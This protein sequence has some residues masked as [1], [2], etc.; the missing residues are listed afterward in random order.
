LIVVLTLAVGAVAFGV[1]LV[2]HR[3]YE[4]HADVLLEPS[5]TDSLFSPGATTGTDPVRA[6]QTETEL[7]Q[8]ESVKD[9]VRR[10]LDVGEAPSVTAEPVGQSNVL[11]ISARDRNASR[12]A[13]IANSYANA[14]IDFRKSTEADARNAA[15]QQLQ[16]QITQ[17]A[18]EIAAVDAEIDNAPAD[19][20]ASVAA[21]LGSQRDALV[22]QQSDLATRQREMR[23][24]S[25]LATGGAQ[26]VV[27]ATPPG[28]AVAPKPVLNLAIGLALGALL[29]IGLAFAFDS[30]DRRSR[31]TGGG[32]AVHATTRGRA[33]DTQGR[34]TPVSTVK[35]RR[36]PEMR[37]PDANGSSAVPAPNRA[38]DPR[39][40]APVDDARVDDGHGPDAGDEAMDAP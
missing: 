8:S 11:R 30:F 16:T 14:Y 9:A 18:G 40:D 17:I 38:K 3:Q 7:V 32:S 26:L 5:V 1:S 34:E 23:V 20:Q 21:R 22:N 10:D 29:G 4:A 37:R 19:Q 27:T 15:D 6:M 25:A 12:A 35:P 2:Q 13:A 39:D 28:S 24:Q 36:R 33:S 31:A